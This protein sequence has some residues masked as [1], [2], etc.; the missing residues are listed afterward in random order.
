M[1]TWGTSVFKEWAEIEEQIKERE[2]KDFGRELG[3]SF[4]GSQASRSREWAKS[5]KHSRRMRPKKRPL[6]LNIMQ[7]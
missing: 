1:V 6:D 3:K 5:S 4:Q 2:T 7:L